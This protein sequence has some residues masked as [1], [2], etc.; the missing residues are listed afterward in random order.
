[1]QLLLRATRFSLNRHR[2]VHQLLCNRLNRDG[3]NLRRRCRFFIV[4]KRAGDENDGENEA[5][6]SALIG[7]DH[8][9]RSLSASKKRYGRWDRESRWSGQYAG[10]TRHA[11]RPVRC[12]CP[13]TH[14]CVRSSLGAECVDPRTRFSIEIR[15]IA[16]SVA[17]IDTLNGRKI[18]DRTFVVLA[19]AMAVT[20]LLVPSTS[21]DPGWSTFFKKRVHRGF[22]RPLLENAQQ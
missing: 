21:P 10:R 18:I 7:A 13:W 3:L 8:P 22:V 11:D 6:C 9:H 16:S 14:W 1:M 5:D 19:A 15:N 20:G 17:C 2:L 4:E 12:L